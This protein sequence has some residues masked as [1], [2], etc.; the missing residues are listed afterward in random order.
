VEHLPSEELSVE[1][2][3]EHLRKLAKSRDI[4]ERLRALWV[5]AAF[6]ER[7]EQCSDG[8]I[9]DLLSVVQEHMGLFSAEFAVTEMARRRLQRSTS[10]IKGIFR[11]LLK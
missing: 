1:E 4:V 2:L 3:F 9:A 8:Q 10:K 5:A 11:R 6:G 7:L